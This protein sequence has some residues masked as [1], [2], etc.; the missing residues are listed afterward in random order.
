MKPIVHENELTM[1]S[2]EISEITGKRHDHVIRDISNMLVTLDIDAPQ[3]WGTQIYGNNNTRKVA[4]LNKELTITLISGYDVKMRHAI[5]KRWLELENKQSVT[6]PN[7]TNPAEAARAWADEVEQKQ[8]AEQQLIEQKPKVEFY[9]NLVERHALMTATQVAQK[10]NISAVKLN[11]FLEEIGGV[12][13]GR[14]KRGRVFTQSFIQ[15]KLGELKQTELGYSQALFTPAAEMW[16]A[17]RLYSEGIVSSSYKS[18][19]Q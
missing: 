13:D 1:S 10:H 19:M 2:L 11:R 12:Y 17:E 15:Q 4:L 8:V 6:L 3:I 9:D 5:T 16:V 18:W 7:F 14:V